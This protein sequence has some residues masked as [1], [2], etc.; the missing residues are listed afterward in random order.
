MNRNITSHTSSDI[1]TLKAIAYGLTM[2]FLSLMTLFG[3]GLV[4]LAFVKFKRLRTIPN[5]FIVSLAT[6]DTL[7]PILREIYVTIAAFL[8]A[9]PFGEAWCYGSA[10]CSYILCACSIAHLMCISIERMVCIRY[11]FYYNVRATPTKALVVILILWCIAVLIGTFPHFGLGDIEFS[12]Q[13]MECEVNWK[14]I[15]RDKILVSLLVVCFFVLPLTIMIVSY[16]LIFSV[17]RNQVRRISVLQAGIVSMGRIQREIKAV[18]TISVIVGVFFVMW[19]PYFLTSV[20]RVIA[21]ENI[22]PDLLR[23]SLVLGYGN[24]GCNPIIYTLMNRKLRNAFKRILKCQ[25]TRVSAASDSSLS[26]SNVRNFETNLVPRPL[27][28]ARKQRLSGGPPPEA[29]KPF[30]S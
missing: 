26:E 20:S 29:Q 18:K 21:D 1:S 19:M 16:G 14:T 7:V 5:Y 23:L 8:R 27:A 6:A 17:A 9:W 4:V 11:P 10:T 2:I 3:N 13:I 15:Q 22:P 25:Q 30:S 24:S 28:V 12:A